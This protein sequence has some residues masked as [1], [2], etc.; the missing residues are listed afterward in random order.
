MKVNLFAMMVARRIL[1]EQNATSDTQRHIDSACRKAGRACHG[2]VSVMVDAS[3]QTFVTQAFELIA[4]LR[5]L[6]TTFAR[7]LNRVDH[8]VAA[9]FPAMRHRS[10]AKVLTTGTSPSTILPSSFHSCDR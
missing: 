7:E 5:V 4:G 8:T 10:L 3:D 9:I 1:S 6:D 2:K